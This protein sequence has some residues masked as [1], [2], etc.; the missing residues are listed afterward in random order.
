MG[1]SDQHRNSGVASSTANTSLTVSLCFLFDSWESVFQRCTLYLGMALKTWPYHPCSSLLLAWLRLLGLDLRKFED[2][3]SE[4]LKTE[5]I[6]GFMAVLQMINVVPF[7]NLLKPVFVWVNDHHCTPVRLVSW[8]NNLSLIFYLYFFSGLAFCYF[9]SLSLQ[10]QDMC[11]RTSSV[12]A[13][14]STIWN[15]EARVVRA[16]RVSFCDMT[17]PDPLRPLRKT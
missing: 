4:S 11:Q 3:L 14:L 1:T 7:P 12:M 9:F 15:K 13:Y 8:I 5:T 2:L 16:L 17:V 6:L 10:D